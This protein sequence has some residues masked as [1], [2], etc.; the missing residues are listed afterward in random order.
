MPCRRCHTLPT[1]RYGLWQDCRS[2][3]WKIAH[4]PHSGTLCRACAI[5]AVKRLNHEARAAQRTV[6]GEVRQ[7]R[8]DA[9][10][11]TRLHRHPERAGGELRNAAPAGL[12][13]TP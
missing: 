13:Q 6:H 2:G 12:Y 8:M 3:R 5:A 11:C 4:R 10:E 9:E 1:D 7:W